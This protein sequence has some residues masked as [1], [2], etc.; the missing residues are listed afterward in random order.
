MLLACSRANRFQGAGLELTVGDL[1]VDELKQVIFHTVRQK[2][3][4][5]RQ[6][7]HLETAILL[8]SFEDGTGKRINQYVVLHELSQVI[9]IYI[10]ALTCTHKDIDLSCDIFEISI[11]D[12]LSLK[13]LG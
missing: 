3:D 9:V 11:V 12:L 13:L 4:Q 7:I 8:V 2:Y 5:I 6:L 10:G 1:H